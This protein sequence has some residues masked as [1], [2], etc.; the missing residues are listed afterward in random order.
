MVVWKYDIL[1][2]SGIQKI[3]MPKGAKVL[4]AQVQRENDGYDDIKIWCLIDNGQAEL[5]LVDRHFILRG[6]GH[7]FAVSNSYP[8][9][10][11]GTVQI[12]YSVWHIFE[13]IGV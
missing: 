11:I 12:D 5:E 7:S 2:K 8:L 10:Y 4:T 1:L 3:R 6:T 9:N 13:I